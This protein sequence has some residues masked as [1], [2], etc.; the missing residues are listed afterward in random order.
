MSTFKQ[1]KNTVYIDDL[2]IP[3]DVFRVLEPNYN[4]QS[5]LE[6]LIY[7]GNQLTVRTNGKTTTISGEWS[8]GDRYISR[9]KDFIVLMSLIS[10]EDSEIN[11]EVDS[12]KDPGLCRENEYPNISELVVALWEHFVEQKS[13]DQSGIYELQQ[14]RIMV[15]DK[16]PMKEK[17]NASDNLSGKT[18]G[19]LPKTTRRTRNRNKSSRRTD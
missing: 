2:E 5:G 19:V 17:S 13:Y 12:I 7:D 16:Y 8:D 9:Q 10:K 18:E 14:K 11:L 3:I 6:V 15:K 1:I 4:P